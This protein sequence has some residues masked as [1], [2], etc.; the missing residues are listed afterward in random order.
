[1]ATHLLQSFLDRTKSSLKRNRLF[2]KQHPRI[3]LVL[4]ACVTMAIFWMVAWYKA[5]DPDFGWHLQAGNTI[6]ESGIP[7]T[8]IFTYTA[9]NFRWVNHEWLSDVF[10]SLVYGWA[11]YNALAVMYGAMWSISLF[12]AGAYKRFYVLIVASLAAATYAGVRATTW[13]V[14]CLSILLY[15]TR[16]KQQK[17]LVF[18]P[19]LMLL[20]ANVHGGFFIGLI[21]IAYYYVIR[22]KAHWLG[23]LAVSVLA[24]FISPYGPRL[25]EE[26]FR[27]MFDSAVRWQIAEWFPASFLLYAIPFIYSLLWAM[28]FVLGLDKKNWKKQAIGLSPLFF[29][30]SLSSNRHFP[31]FVIVSSGEVATSLAKVGK[32]IPKKLDTRR[33]AMVYVLPV[34]IVLLVGWELFVLTYKVV[35]YGSGSREIAYPQK[36]VNYLQK[37]PC[38]GN[39]FNS[40]NYGGYLIWKLPG[41]P[42][43]I[44]GRL[45][46]WRD[47]NNVRYF[48][49]YK[50]VALDQ[51]AINS[52]DFEKYNI[53]CVLWLNSSE[54]EPLVQGLE[55]SNWQKIDEASDVT[56][57]LWI[58]PDVKIDKPLPR[59]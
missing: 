13:T 32:R 48:D 36:A 33:K 53:R 14:L 11:G 42:L 46:H 10:L 49:R 45:P 37:N 31:L 50:N 5:F 38:T 30:A 16:S 26:V 9:S 4:K 20:W 58:A 59:F 6:R 22:K 2:W 35:A 40:Y 3:L 28:G 21:V 44:D 1:M 57:T 19:A 56:Y 34:I 43:Y 55:R 24:T 17:T 51:D 12:I 27:T 29:L 52:E 47:E 8:D 23:L 15:I 39:I 41:T 18:I 25:Y 54:K 7:A